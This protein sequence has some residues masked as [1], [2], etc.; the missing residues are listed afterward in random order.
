MSCTSTSKRCSTASIPS[1][2]RPLLS[3]LPPTFQ[4]DNE[5]Q[6]SVVATSAAIQAWST[7]GDVYAY[8]NNDWE[9]YAIKKP[10]HL[11]AIASPPSRM[12]EHSMA[13]LGRS[14]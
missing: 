9:G 5:L 14:P 12:N 10:S 4:R 8:F 11:L 1:P 7:T 3:Q 2:R 13:R 6:D